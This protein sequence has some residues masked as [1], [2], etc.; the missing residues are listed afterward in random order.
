MRTPSDSPSLT[1]TLAGL[2]IATCVVGI[3]GSL[4]VAKTTTVG[5]VVFVIHEGRGWGI[6]TGDALLPAALIATITALTL[7]V[8]R[9]RLRHP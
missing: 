8:R 1:P 9:H 3:A 5:P 2:L 7:I 4:Y 6:H